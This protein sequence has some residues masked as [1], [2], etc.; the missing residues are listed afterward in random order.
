MAAILLGLGVAAVGVIVLVLAVAAAAIIT[1]P[2]A[3]TAPGGGALDEL[4]S[5]GKPIEASVAF[6]DE[7]SIGGGGTIGA[8]TGAL[9][10]TLEGNVKPGCEESSVFVMGDAELEWLIVAGAMFALAA[11]GAATELFD[12][13]PPR[14]RR[15]GSPEPSPSALAPP[16][17]REPEKFNADI[18]E[19]F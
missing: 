8:V 9:L 2:A 19:K 17:R 11:V 7:L 12:P 10:L 1:A 14:R 18:L 5:V 15:V 13:P 3:A 6:E 4:L 16:R